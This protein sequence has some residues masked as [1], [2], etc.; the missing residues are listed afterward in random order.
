MLSLLTEAVK[1]IWPVYANEKFN[2]EPNKI[3]WI[4]FVFYF[5][6][7]GG[8]LLIYFLLYHSRSS[9]LTSS[10]TII[11]ILSSII[12]FFQGS[13]IK[14]YEVSSWTQIFILFLSLGL[15][16]YHTLYNVTILLPILFYHTDIL[17]LLLQIYYHLHIYC[18]P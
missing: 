11:L 3:A 1:S 9:H 4:F 7:S 10:P 6:N 18:L 14:D 17:S 8:H 2:M 13:T 15:I 16:S 12:I 5:L